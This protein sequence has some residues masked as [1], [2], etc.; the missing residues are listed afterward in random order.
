LISFH[1][2]HTIILLSP[3]TVPTNYRI[4]VRKEKVKSF[5]KHDDED[6]N[7]GRW[8]N[9]ERSLFQAGKLRK[10][11]QVSLEKIG[12]KWCMLATTSR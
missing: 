9:R 6:K 12:L 3:G 7:F 2:T 4:K 11:R 8:V 10:D 1:L 5:V